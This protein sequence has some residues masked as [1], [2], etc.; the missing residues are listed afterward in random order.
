MQAAEILTALQDVGAT[1]WISGDKLLVEPRSR[2][3]DDLVPEIKS[4]KAEIMALLPAPLPAAFH[5][6]PVTREETAELMTFLADPVAFSQWF[7]TL[8][9]QCD[10]AE[11]DEGE[12]NQR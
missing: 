1:A 10:P 12:Q 4:H 6:P 11:T 9:A 8:M 3:P 7:E 5:R 2:V